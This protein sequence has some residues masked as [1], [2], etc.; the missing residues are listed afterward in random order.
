MVLGGHWIYFTRPL[1]KS[2]HSISGF[3]ECSKV[4]RMNIGR[5]SLDRTRSFKICFYHG[6]HCTRDTVYSTD[7]TYFWVGRYPGETFSATSPRTRKS[8]PH[9]DT[10]EENSR[11]A[12]DQL[13]SREVSFCISA[14]QF[15]QGAFIIYY[16]YFIP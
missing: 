16:H 9:P 1:Y 11:I 6:I 14:F 13:V 3:F 10:R 12:A 5:S 15:Q 8:T 2:R 7:T 4:N